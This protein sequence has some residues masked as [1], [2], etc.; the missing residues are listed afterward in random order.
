MSLLGEMEKRRHN[1][2][3]TYHYL[4]NFLN[5]Y[6]LHVFKNQGAVYFSSKGLLKTK[7][8]RSCRTAEEQI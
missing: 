2:V 7:S 3:F 5:A 6:T 4:Y 1:P 8:H